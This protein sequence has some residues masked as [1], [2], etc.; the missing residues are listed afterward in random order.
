MVALTGIEPV[1][2]RFTSVSLSLGGC[3]FSASQFATPA[4]SAIWTAHVLPWCCPAPQ[5]RLARK[6]QI[7]SA[8]PGDIPSQ[9]D[10]F[11]WTQM[12]LDK[13]I[14]TLSYSIGFSST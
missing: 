2:E 6:P 1:E 8:K 13:T 14:R 10:G 3:V 9:Q 4:R 7:L 5:K 12:A 11:T